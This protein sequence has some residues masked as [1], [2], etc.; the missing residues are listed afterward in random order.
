[1]VSESFVTRERLR[2]ERLRIYRKISDIESDFTSGDLTEADYQMQRGQLRIA[3]AETLKQESVGT[4]PDS[5]RDEELENE[6]SRQRKLTVHSP[7]GG[8]TL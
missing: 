2:A 3:A 7:E 4:K 5:V 8:D 1:M 6:I